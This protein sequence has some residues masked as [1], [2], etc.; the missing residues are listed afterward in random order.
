MAIIENLDIE[1]ETITIADTVF[2]Y[3]GLSAHKH[4][5]KDVVENTHFSKVYDMSEYYG[6]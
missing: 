3:I 6:E 5:F 1:N 2:R 4:T